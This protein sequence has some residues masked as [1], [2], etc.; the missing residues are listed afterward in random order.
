M[1]TKE[2]EN[3]E[4]VAA[5]INAAFECGYYTGK[6]ENGSFLHTDAME[7]REQLSREVVRR[8][9][10]NDGHLQQSEGMPARG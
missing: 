8:L 5:L 3:G 6:G 10:G 9:E 7:R 2:M 1:N 4:L